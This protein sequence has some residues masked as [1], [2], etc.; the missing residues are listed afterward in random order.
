MSWWNPLDW[1][2]N[3]VADSVSRAFDELGERIREDPR[4]IL[5]PVGMAGSA[6]ALIEG[7]RSAAKA[8]GE[9]LGSAVAHDFVTELEE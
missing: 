8:A 5:Y 3:A 6:V 9:I 4:I 2:A 7:G 1:V